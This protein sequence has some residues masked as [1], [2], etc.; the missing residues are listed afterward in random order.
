MPHI[1]VT[2]GARDTALGTTWDTLVGRAAPNVFLHPAA[3]AA[4]AATKFAKLK[5]LC[6][7]DRSANT[8]RLVGVWALQEESLAPL[9]PAVLT[10][11]PYDFSFLS[12]PMIDPA[13]VAE[14]VPAFLDA[15]RD[16]PRLPKVLRLNYLDGDGEIYAALSRALAARGG[17]TLL[18]ETRGRPFVSR[19]DGQKLSGSTRKKLRQDWN[20]LCA[21]GAVDIVDARNPAAL[22][23]GF[24]TFLALEA[25]SWK[26]REGTALLS[27]ARDAAFARA[28]IA[29][30]GAANSAS[31]DLLRLDGKPI[32]AQV[33]LYC[34]RTAYTWKTAFDE[35]YGKY[36]PGAVLVDQV[37][38][39]LFEGG[40][41]DA[42]DSC[43]PEGGFMAKLWTG[44]RPTVDLL[45]A[46]EP[47]RS[48]TFALVAVIER[49]YRALKRRRDSFR[50]RASQRPPSP[51]SEPQSPAPAAS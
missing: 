23:E 6:A 18:L 45:A 24:Q 10:T 51:A 48:P 33:L 31:V 21:L 4:V 37:T 38:A 13:Y 41:I 17:E 22:H 1:E 2:L 19:G 5:V 3:L 39:R 47:H 20:R 16:H 36:S 27:H 9:V 25:K 35:D 29:N 30:L 26:G 12:S 14:A 44:R 42:I 15:I 11:P 8:E 32:A 50:A 46:L 49:G 28:L 34:G 7:W 40:A 43:S